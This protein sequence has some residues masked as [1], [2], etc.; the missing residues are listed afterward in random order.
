[1]RG[2]P[3]A[4][5]GVLGIVAIALVLGLGSHAAPAAQAQGNSE[6]QAAAPT[7]AGALASFIPNKGQFGDPDENGIQYMT[8]AGGL[9]AWFMP[10]RV[11]MLS[12]ERAADAA[13]DDPGQAHAVDLEFIDASPEVRLV[14]RDQKPGKINYLFGPGETSVTGLSAFGELSY[15]GLWPGVD[16]RVQNT[17]GTIT[18]QPA[19]NDS[20][21]VLAPF[22]KTT[23]EVQPGVSPDVIRYRYDAGE[24]QTVSLTGDG[25]LQVATSLGSLYELAPRA[26]AMPT[27]D[28]GRVVGNRR[29]VDVAFQLEDGVVSFDVGRVAADETLVIDPYLVW[30]V[31]AAGTS[32]DY[33]AGMVVDDTGMY[34]SGSTSLSGTGWPA[35]TGPLVYNAGYDWIV[36]KAASTAR[37][38]AVLELPRRLDHGL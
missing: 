23:Y 14:G 22:L 20:D 28:D 2:M 27:S 16:L 35:A 4:R 6:E 1:M 25:R 34:L 15:R 38:A 9:W 13:E 8:R 26:W 5:L 32:T 37:T 21:R 30:A 36:M 12:N 17:F 7:I 19:P 10:D 33:Q 3:L 24:G 18:T 11:R 29:P 31:L